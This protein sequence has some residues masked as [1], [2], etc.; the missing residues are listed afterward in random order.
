MNSAHR[1]SCPPNNK[2]PQADRTE[3]CPLSCKYNFFESEELTIHAWELKCSDC[4]WRDTVGFRS[5][6]VDEDDT[7]DP[8]ACPFC[9]QTGL[10]PGKNPCEG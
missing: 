9:L 4:G 8:A 5:D 6:E 10:S 2:C 3:P 1:P 7:R